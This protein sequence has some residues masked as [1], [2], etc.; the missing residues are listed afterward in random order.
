MTQKTFVIFCD[1]EH[2]DGDHCFPD[3][4][5]DDQFSIRENLMKFD[6]VSSVRRAA[7]AAGW[8]RHGGIDYCPDCNAAET[9][10]RLP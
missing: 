9:G 2:G 6:S 3:Y 8:G 5:R 10:H 4:A 7:K 1:N